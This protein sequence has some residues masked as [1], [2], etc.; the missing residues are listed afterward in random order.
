MTT[1]ETVVRLPSDAYRDDGVAYP[2]PTMQHVALARMVVGDGPVRSCPHLTA[3]TPGTPE[4]VAY[5]WMP[6]TVLCTF[7]SHV[8]TV[9]GASHCM[10][11]ARRPTE[12]VNVHVGNVTVI[13]ELCPD[14]WAAVADEEDEDA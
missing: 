5:T 11:G 2:R 9:V 8:H 4:V 6:G 1:E 7:C 10:C 12:R 3:D 13:G 14:C